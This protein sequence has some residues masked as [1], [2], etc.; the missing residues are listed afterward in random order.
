[1]SEQD[2]YWDSKELEDMWKASE[3]PDYSDHWYLAGPM[4]GYPNFNKETFD[5]VAD[6]VYSGPH[7]YKTFNP[8][9]VFN[10]DQTRELADYLSIELPILMQCKGVIFLPNWWRSEGARIEYMVAQATGKKMY[11]FNKDCAPW[12]LR[13]VR[14]PVELHAAELVYGDRTNEYKDPYTDF[15]GTALQWSATAGQSIDPKQV[16]L[17]MAQLKLNRL[18]NNITHR[19]SLVDTIGYMLCLDWMIRKDEKAK[20]CSF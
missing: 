4:R 2:S 15:E 9:S 1:M 10:G 3:A 20:R 6:F 13:E 7:A 12:C 14:K 19:D 11:E 16:P 8:H 18:N 5:E 17:M